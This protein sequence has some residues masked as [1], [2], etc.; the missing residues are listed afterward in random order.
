MKATITSFF[1]FIILSSC[2]K[3][4]NYSP[5]HIKQTSGRY[6]YNDNEVIDVYYDETIYS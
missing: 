4:I 5:E 3:N 6:L 1:L 2:S